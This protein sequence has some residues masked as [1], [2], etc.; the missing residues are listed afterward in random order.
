MKSPLIAPLPRCFGDYPLINLGLRRERNCALCKSLEDCK[1]HNALPNCPTMSNPP[2]PPP[3]MSQII[4]SLD[5][6]A[7]TLCDSMSHDAVMSPEFRESCVTRFKDRLRYLF[8][9]NVQHLTSVSPKEEEQ[10]EEDKPSALDEQVG[11]SHYKGM[12]IQH[13][14][15]CQAN[16]LGW[17]E[18]SAIKY[19]CRHGSKNKAQDVKKAIHYCQILLQ[20]EY[21]DAAESSN[22]AKT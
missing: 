12:K 3:R 16:R 21:P 20:L 7:R 8:G 18:S 13:A 22:G 1:F 6:I 11:G 10:E 2:P 14:E 9:A 4:Y 5:G 15:F 17:C 19:L